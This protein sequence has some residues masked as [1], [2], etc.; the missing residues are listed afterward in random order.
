METIDIVIHKALTSALQ[1]QRD[2]AM[3]EACNAK[4]EMLILREEK[5]ELEKKVE[6]LNNQL[7]NVVSMD[8]KE[9][10]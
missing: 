4:A 1:E 6:E 2:R 3:N 7:G 10:K 8:K 5:T 9:K